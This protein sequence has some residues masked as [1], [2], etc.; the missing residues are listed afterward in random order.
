MLASGLG[1][2]IMIALVRHLSADLSSPQVVFLRNAAA[3]VFFLPWL[4]RVGVSNLKTRRFRM[5][6]ARGVI[7][8]IAMYMWFYSLTI[9]ELP[10]ATA[11]SF[12]A[13][14]LNALLAVALFKESYGPHRWAALFIGFA[15]AWVVLRPGTDAFDPTHLIVIASA[16]MWALSGVI[17]KSLTHT[18]DP[19]KVAFFMVLFMTPLSLPLALLYW[20]PLPLRLWPWIAF[21]GLISCLFQIALS[22][23]IALAPFYVILPFDFTRLI[24]VSLIAYFFFDEVLTWNTL[25]GALLIMGGAVYSAYRESRASRR[26][27]RGGRGA[28]TLLSEE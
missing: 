25:Y 28:A 17:I 6:T 1:A 23:A 26:K 12:T 24:F 8:L 18:D 15:G 2:S 20:E 21:L 13:P 27:N 22:K 3:L 9:I 7:G 10:T 19:T 4:F 5:Y 16:S 14:L 11:L